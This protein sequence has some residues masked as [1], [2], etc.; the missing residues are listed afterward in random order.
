[1]R[2]VRYFFIISP[3]KKTRLLENF[4]YTVLGFFMNNIIPLRLGEVIRAKVTGERLKIS[5]STALA[6]IVVERLM[7]IIVYILFF[8]LIMNTLPF[9]ELVKNSF[10]ICA[11][12]FGVILVVLY[13]VSIFDSKALNVISKFPLPMKLKQFVISVSNKFL[14][15]LTILKSKKALITSFSF[16]FVVWI[17]ESFS[18]IVVAYSCGIILTPIEGIFTVIIVGIA[19]IIPTAPGYLGA[20]EMAGLAA[21]TVLG[22][23][24]NLALAAIIISHVMQLLVNFIL[25]FSSVIYAKISFKDLFNF[26]EIKTDEE[27]KNND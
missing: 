9:P 4:P 22:I 25:G 8:F 14:D 10:Y 3:I 19:S 12:L 23:E 26:E 11:V 13:V 16:S 5:R 20:V 1:M 6:T 27:Q 17:I 15:G 21:L 18:F 7:D 24:E 2:S